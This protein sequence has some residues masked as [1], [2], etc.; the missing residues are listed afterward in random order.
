[1]YP[2]FF[3]FVLLLIL[4]A[5]EKQETHQPVQVAIQSPVPG[6]VI[7][8]DTLRFSVSVIDSGDGLLKM[9]LINENGISIL[10]PKVFKLNTSDTI[11]DFFLT[12]HLNYT[13]SATL[14]TLWLR[15][16]K[17]H[18][19]A[20]RVM[21]VSVSSYS[22]AFILH[23][24]QPG[25]FR[26]TQLLADGS[27]PIDQKFNGIGIVSA[28]WSAPAQTLALLQADGQSVLAAK[29]PFDELSYTLNSSASP[30]KISLVASDGN[31]F[32]IGEQSGNLRA[33]RASDGSLLLSISG[34]PDSLPYAATNC[35]QW[36]AVAYRSGA[37]KH[38]VRIFYRNTGARHSLWPLGGKVVDMVW[39]NEKEMITAIR[40][41][42]GIELFEISTDPPAFR[43]LGSLNLHS[44]DTLV[45]VPGIAMLVRSGQL[46]T[47]YSTQGQQLWQLQWSSS[48]HIIAVKPNS[49]WIRNSQNLTEISLSGQ[50]GQVVVVP[51]DASSGTFFQPVYTPLKQK[52]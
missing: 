41:P 1:M 19:K 12:E 22:D 36:T 9:S 13:G 52:N 10:P 37:N 34:N 39:R 29:T 46:I 49:V 16:G 11:R 42:N 23:R 15:N 14:V 50:L 43:L 18:T 47:K 3:F 32:W 6:S 35:N 40:R 8:S 5:C 28:V 17:Q 26:L 7:D 51:E 4:S 24:S 38:A 48:P 25:S 21:L 30:H 44:N 31:R 45:F 27:I 20:V 2:K 33:V